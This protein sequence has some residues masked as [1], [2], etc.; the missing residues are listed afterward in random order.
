[1]LKRKESNASHELLLDL[2]SEGEESTSDSDDDL[3]GLGIFS[4]ITSSKITKKV[5]QKIWKGD[6][7]DI[8]K[9]YYG[10]DES[11]VQM[12][13]KKSQSDT[14]TSLKSS[15]QRQVNNILSWSRAFQLYASIYC[16][17]FPSE[18][19]AMFQYMTIVQTLAKKGQN[20]LLYD[21]KFRSLRAKQ[22]IPWEK[23]H[24]ET[25]L[26]SSLST[27]NSKDQSQNKGNAFPKQ[28]FRNG[29]CWDFQR[30]G[31]CTKTACSRIHKCALCEGEHSGVSCRSRSRPNLPS[32]R[33][34]KTHNVSG[35]SQ[36]GANASPL[37]P[38][39]S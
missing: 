4:N 17:K 21:K 31:K 33:S 5:K 16:I 11:N 25:H 36:H 15:P 19:S 24:I 14:V 27:K 20:W 23:L 7:I 13:I 9:L 34:F 18:S 37:P 35:S 10:K 30:S 38:N 3:Q 6:Y 29:Y 8:S 39:S 26:Y 2:L 12:H 32:G 28:L 1:M 22:H